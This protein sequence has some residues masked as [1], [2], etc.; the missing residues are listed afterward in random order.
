MMDSVFLSRLQFAV[1]IGVHFLFVTISLG[2]VWL[3][4]AVE[5]MAWRT[6]NQEWEKAGRFFGRIFVITFIFGAV[7][8]MVMEFQFGTNWAGFSKFT[9]DV[10]GTPLAVEGM[11][12]FFLESVFLGVYVFG[13]NKLSKGFLWFS[14]LMVSLGATFSAFWILV[15]NSWM[16]TP[17]GFLI[18]G[19]KIILNDFS[20]VVFSKSIWPRFFHTMDAVIISGALF[21][22]GVSAYLYLKNNKSLLAQKTLKLAIVIAFIMSV[23]ELYPFG[24]WSAGQIAATQPTKFAAI[25]SVEKTQRNAPLVIFGVPVDNPPHLIYDIRVPDLLSWL[26]FRDIDAEVKGMDLYAPDELPPYVLTFSS[27][28]LMVALGLLFIIIS[29]IGTLL[30]YKELIFRFKWFLILLIL[31]I[32]LP[33]IACQLGW[34]TTEVGR[35]PWIVYGVLKTSQ[36]VSTNVSANEVLLS[37]VFFS[38]LYLVI[39]AFYVFIIVSEVR[40]GPEP[41]INSQGY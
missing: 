27:F 5:T 9:G 38:F 8:G 25:E 19:S 33:L 2:I 24:D 14:I 1:T 31:N 3:L 11:F 18:S 32:P 22:A 6:K 7:T 17:D 21:M 40:R 15:A 30:L 23:L 10:F 41:L 20:K 12:S 28:H 4:F 35:Q 34:I 26:A 29:G 13:R 39:T 37:L 36:A 16:N